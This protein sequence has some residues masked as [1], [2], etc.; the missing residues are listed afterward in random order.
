M[1]QRIIQVPGPREDRY[2]EENVREE[3][4]ERGWF[5]LEIIII[6]KSLLDL[7]QLKFSVRKD[8]PEIYSQFT[9]T[10]P[11]AV[12]CFKTD[13]LGCCRAAGPSAPS[14]SDLWGHQF[15]RLQVSK[16]IVVAGHGAVVRCFDRESC[17]TSTEHV[18]TL[19]SPPAHIRTSTR[20]GV[21]WAEWHVSAL[22]GWCLW[23][24]LNAA[25]Q[26]GIGS[27]IKVKQQMEWEKLI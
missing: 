5:W 26:C 7:L 16:L 24:V 12:A 4:I 23:K 14:R 2:H 11:R 13:V 9:Q 19:S 21:W 17:I 6:I 25:L 3:P 8:E 10:F 22:S 27:S 15:A 20:M 18:D 1:Q